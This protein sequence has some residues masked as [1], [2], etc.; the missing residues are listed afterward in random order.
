M[1]R[2]KARE[3]NLP[4]E[5]DLAPDLPPLVMGDQDRLGQVLFNL[6]GNA[7]KFTQQGEVRV[8]VRRREDRLEFAVSDTGVGIPEDKMDLIFQSFSQAD[9]SFRR[10]F[11]GTGLGLAISQGLVELMGGEI[12]VRSDH[13]KGSVFHFTLPL[14]AIEERHPE[15]GEEQRNAKS[16]E[17]QGARILLAEDEPMIRELVLAGLSRGGWLAEA[18]ENGL[19]ALRKWEEGGFDLI[20][21]DLQMPELSG[22]EATRQIRQKGGQ[23]ICIVGLTAHV[24]REVKEECLAAGMD[25]VLTKPVQIQEL[26][27]TIDGCISERKQGR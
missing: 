10:K 5:L 2:L 22:L 3:K 13:G 4:L 7:V 27:S 24:S 9:S 25:K 11:G 16:A 19:E 26:L 20:L 15:A 18:A 12:S 17:S 1:M 21:M 23:D 14:K 8:S 6:I